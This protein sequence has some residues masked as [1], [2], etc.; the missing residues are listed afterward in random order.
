MACTGFGQHGV[1]QKAP[2]TL[3]STG[4]FLWGFSSTPLNVRRSFYF[5]KFYLAAIVAFELFEYVFV[6][7]TDH[8]LS[9]LI[10][11]VRLLKPAGLKPIDFA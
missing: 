10:Q 6:F 5:H 4:A 3:I 8:L 9:Q 2:V 11:A 7:L 1:E